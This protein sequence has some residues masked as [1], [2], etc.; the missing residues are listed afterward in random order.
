MQHTRILS[1]ME[2]A[3]LKKLREQVREIRKEMTTRREHAHARAGKDPL[4]ARSD[5]YQALLERKLGRTVAD[6]EQHVAQ[7]RCQE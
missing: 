3:E 4:A 7:H 2:C 5:G 1:R 6:L